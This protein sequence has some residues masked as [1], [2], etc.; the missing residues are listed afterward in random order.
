MNPDIA[1]KIVASLDAELARR[2]QKRDADEEARW[3]EESDGN[4][5]AFARRYLD[6]LVGRL[7]AKSAEEAAEI[8]LASAGDEADRDQLERV[9]Q[10]AEWIVEISEKV[11]ILEAHRADVAA[12]IVRKCGPPEIRIRSM[13]KLMPDPSRPNADPAAPKVERTGRRR[14]PA[15][16]MPGTPEADGIWKCGQVLTFNPRTWEGMLRASDG[17]EYPLSHGALAHSGLVTLI[18]GMKCEFRI[19]A[20]E[21]D[22]LKSAW[23]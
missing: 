14:D 2:R 5:V 7:G 3:L 6:R 16:A 9:E 1:A 13:T 10:F 15:L 4:H 12:G 21:A 23:H 20:G 8:V 17:S 19:V 11:E 18:P 22:Q